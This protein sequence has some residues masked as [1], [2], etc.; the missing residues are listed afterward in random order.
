[1]AALGVWYA[2]AALA[3]IAVGTFVLG[4]DFLDLGAKREAPF[5]PCT[6]PMACGPWFPDGWDVFRFTAA[7]LVV[8]VVI[9]L[10]LRAFLV[11][12]FESPVAAGSLAAVTAWTASALGAC[13]V[14]GLLA[15]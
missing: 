11:R 8:S 6:E 15:R 3:P 10:P 1:M 4:A 14:S 12:R 7:F 5:K 2:F 13:C 9:A